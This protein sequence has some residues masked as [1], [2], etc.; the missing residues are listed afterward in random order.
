M[1]ALQHHAQFQIARRIVE[2]G[3][4][5][6]TSRSLTLNEIMA[7]GGLARDRQSLCGGIAGA[8]RLNP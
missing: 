8:E 3:T 2:F 5:T 7:V 4:Q 1:L 6:E